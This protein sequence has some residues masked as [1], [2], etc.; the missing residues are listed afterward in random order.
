MT[1]VRETLVPEEERAALPNPKVQARGNKL[2]IGSRVASPYDRLFPN[3]DAL[4]R[5]KV[6]DEIQQLVAN[7]DQHIRVRATLGSSVG[8]VY[9]SQEPMIE[10]LVK[11]FGV[12]VDVQLI[13]N[14]KKAI[15]E[16]L[17]EDES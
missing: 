4:Q 9:E 5:L 11:G 6:P 13:S 15:M 17:K 2:V 1:R 12:E 10:Q 3:G 7:I 16:A 14:V 8:D